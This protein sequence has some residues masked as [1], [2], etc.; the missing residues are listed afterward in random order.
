[1][2]RLRRGILRSLAESEL[3]FSLRASPRLYTR[4]TERLGAVQLK[5]RQRLVRST[6]PAGLG[7]WLAGRA[8]RVC[9][10]RSSVGWRVDNPGGLAL[11]CLV[12]RTRSGSRRLRRADGAA[13]GGRRRRREPRQKSVF[14]LFWL[15]SPL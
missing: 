9:W 11:V 10:C 12:G 6:S 4:Q 1:M 5:C 2:K 13:G 14:R 7:R 8:G 3:R 15:P